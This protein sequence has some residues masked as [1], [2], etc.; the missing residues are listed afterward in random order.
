MHIYIYIHDPSRFETS[1][2]DNTNIDEAARYLISH[3][4]KLEEENTDN[5]DNENTN[6]VNLNDQQQQQNQNQNSGCC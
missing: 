3:I 2:K 4:V 5:D 1:A 6:T